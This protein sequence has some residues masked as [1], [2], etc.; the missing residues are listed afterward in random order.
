MGEGSSPCSVQCIR[1]S[2][3]ATFCEVISQSFLRFPLIRF[4][5]Q[6]VFRSSLL[7]VS[8]KLG[9]CF[10]LTHSFFGISNERIN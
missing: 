1:M 2:F 5:F 8:H 7:D 4:L 10:R 9:V 3:L 6:H